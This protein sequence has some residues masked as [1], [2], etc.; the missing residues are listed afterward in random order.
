MLLFAHSRYHAIGQVRVQV[1][2]LTELICVG[3]SPGDNMV[4]KINEYEIK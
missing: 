3:S 1:V 2:I 4:T